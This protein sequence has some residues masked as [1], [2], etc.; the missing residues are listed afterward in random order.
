MKCDFLQSS[1]WLHLSFLFKSPGVAA[2]PGVR[3]LLSGEGT[4]TL[5]PYL[6]LFFKKLPLSHRVIQLRVGVAYF[7]FHDKELKAFGQTL[8]RAVPGDRRPE[9]RLNTQVR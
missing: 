8:F 2:R 5:L 6:G 4:H 3:A 7:L 9:E 1:L